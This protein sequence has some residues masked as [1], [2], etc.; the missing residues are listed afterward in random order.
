MWAARPT[1]LI[2][3]APPKATTTR[4]G[5]AEVEVAVWC[6]S[7]PKVRCA[8]HLRLNVGSYPTSRSACFPHEQTVGGPP[9]SSLACT[10]TAT[11]LWPR[12]AQPRPG[13][14]A[15]G[16]VLLKFEPRQVT[17]PP[18]ATRSWPSRPDPQ[19][20]ADRTPATH[21]LQMES[22]GP[23][24]RSRVD[25]RWCSSLC[26]LAGRPGC[27]RC[28]GPSRS[29]ASDWAG[30]TGT[31]NGPKSRALRHQP[32]RRP[33]HR[34]PEQSRFQGRAAQRRQPRGRPGTVFRQEPPAG[35]H[36]HPGTV[37]AITVSS[38]APTVNVGDLTQL[39]QQQ[40][41]ATLRHQ[42][43]KVRILTAPSPNLPAGLV[44]AQSPAPSVAVPV[45][46]TVNLTVSSPPARKG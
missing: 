22:S 36:R 6:V 9:T 23:A 21:T 44:T 17:I 39:P 11:V 46:S 32:A 37:I 10:T 33:G 2:H 19:T 29:W 13:G 40:A 1:S 18:E 15:D 45:G 41:V 26:C 28:S 3:F 31:S 38:G 16:K 20:F 25:V 27:W 30:G 35:A 7:S 4:S 42:G 14:M 8:E 24:N 5:L 34:Q 43:L 12:E